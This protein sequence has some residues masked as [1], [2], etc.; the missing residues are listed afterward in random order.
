[1][2]N[3]LNPVII[4]GPIVL[5]LG[6]LLAIVCIA[7]FLARPDTEPSA[8]LLRFLVIALVIGIAT[9]VAGAAIGIAT[10]C[11]NESTGNLCALGGVLGL[12]PL[13]SG[14]CI[15]GY[16]CLWLKGSRSAA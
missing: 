5:G 6:L 1:M 9:F 13:L 15:G 8:P 4:A 12:G 10:F 11:P 16:A 3:S 7:I 14:I 2:A